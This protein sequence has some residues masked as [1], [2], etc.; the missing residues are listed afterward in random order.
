MAIG[1]NIKRLRK[2]KGL[3]QK[4]LGTLC[5]LAD[6]AIRRSELGGANPKIETVKK[7]AQALNVSI[8]AI[9][10]FDIEKT[11]KAIQEANDAVLAGEIPDKEA[12]TKQFIKSVYETVATFDESEYTPEELEK[13]K[14]YAAFIKSNRK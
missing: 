10:G 13:I 5:G 11:E 4:E 6:S 3:T 14:E 2:A 12:A 1:E 8:E 7:I 9:Y